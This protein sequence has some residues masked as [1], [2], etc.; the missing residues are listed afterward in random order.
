MLT[1]TTSLLVWVF[2][3][4]Y[5]KMT[6]LLDAR[7]GS[8]TFLAW[9]NIHASQKLIRVGTYKTIGIGKEISIWIDF[10]LPTRPPWAP[11][12]KANINTST[13]KVGDLII[14]QT[15]NW[16]HEVINNIIM[17]EDLKWINVIRLGREIIQNRITLGSITKWHILCQTR[18]LG[19]GT[20]TRWLSYSSEL[21]DL[22]WNPI[23]EQIWK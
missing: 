1:V 19:F 9:H 22:S 6:Y 17:E 20:H 11:K 23:F 15:R 21:M 8:R 3:R 13:R 12:R 14:Y 2:K 7:L 4:R 16:N 5:F 10:W 18:I